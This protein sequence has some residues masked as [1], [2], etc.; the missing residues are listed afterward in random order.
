[1]R[2]LKNRRLH[3]NMGNYEH[4]EDTA[5]IDLDTNTD[6]DLL[7]AQGVDPN[8]LDSV[9]QFVE[10]ELAAVLAPGIEEAATYT[11]E[12]SSFVLPYTHDRNKTTNNRKK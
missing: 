12:E 8:D 9:Y 5:S 2:V 4:I 7:R 11:D 3:I 1:M 6:G 10:D